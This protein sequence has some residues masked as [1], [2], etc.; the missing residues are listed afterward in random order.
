MWVQNPELEEEAV[1]GIDTLCL[2]NDG[3][4][5]PDVKFNDIFEHTSIFFDSKKDFIFWPSFFLY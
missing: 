1:S 2:F 4:I 3:L 5:L